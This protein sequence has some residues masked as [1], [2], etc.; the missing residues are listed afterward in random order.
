MNC[1]DGSTCN[2]ILQA[3]LLNSATVTQTQYDAEHTKSAGGR[4]IFI[5]FTIGKSDVTELPPLGGIVDQ[6][7]FKVTAATK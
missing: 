6:S 1:E 5:L 4:D 3:K 7:N 2:E